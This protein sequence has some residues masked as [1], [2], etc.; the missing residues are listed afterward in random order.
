M[1]AFLVARGAAR[2]LRIK[3]TRS[4]PL[5]PPEDQGGGQAQHHGFEQVW[6]RA[7]KILATPE[8]RKVGPWHKKGANSVCM[9]TL[10]RSVS[11]KSL[12][13]VTR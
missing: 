10:F 6:I 8:A 4:P 2:A 1:E 12:K 7:E 5:Q 3:W 9:D 13:V 11:I